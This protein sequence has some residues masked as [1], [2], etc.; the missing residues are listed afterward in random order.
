MWFQRK[1]KHERYYLFPGMGGN[2]LRRKQRMF[3]ILSVS[4]A[5]GTALLLAGVLYLINHPH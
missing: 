5:I 1:R 4:T 3:F 2:Q